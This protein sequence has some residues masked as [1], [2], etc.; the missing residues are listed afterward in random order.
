MNEW[1][2]LRAWG[3]TVVLAPTK[4]GKLGIDL[5]SVDRDVKALNQTNDN[6]RNSAHL[7]SPNCKR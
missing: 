6:Q 7:P 5:Q 2:S 1:A 3:A 4:R